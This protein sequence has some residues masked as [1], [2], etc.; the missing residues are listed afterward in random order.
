[1][2]KP[3]SKTCTADNATLIRP[4]RAGTNGY[5]TDTI[6]DSDGL[7]IIT[8]DGTP[9]TGGKKVA[10]GIYRNESTKYTYTLGGSGDT[11]S[12][13][14][15]KDGNVNKIIIR[16]WTIA[17]NLS[18]TLDD[19]QAPLPQATLSG[20]LNLKTKTMANDDEWRVAA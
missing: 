13:F 5:G 20:D 10:E 15:Q 3:A 6:T 4:T 7:G 16:N 9:I 1:M 14:I 19:T 18:I 8:V 17:N 11:Q 12:L 2:I